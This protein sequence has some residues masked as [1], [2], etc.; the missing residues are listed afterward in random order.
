[1]CTAM[2]KLNARKPFRYSALALACLMLYCARSGLHAGWERRSILPGTDFAT[3]YYIADSGQPGKNVLLFAPHA[4][5][6]SAG[7]ALE[8]FTKRYAPKQGLLIACPWPVVPAKKLQA[9]AYIEDINRQF[10]H[11]ED[12]FTAIDVIAH[13]VQAWLRKYKIDYV[14]N[15]HEGYG[16]FRLSWTANYGQSIFI[17][18]PS[19][20][21]FAES[22]AKRANARIP[23]PD[24]FLTAQL[25]MP[26]T[27]TW[28]CHT[29]GIPSMGI[30]IQRE[31]SKEKRLRYQNIILQEFFSMIGL[32]LEPIKK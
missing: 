15:L 30:E 6:A 28:Y 22:L 31:L 21:P 9:R 11:T 2:Q 1:M 14:L 25:P 13:T 17:D 20:L 5:E 7:L 32:S 24:R 16:K 10:S 29:L 4:D 8:E 18:S 23:E 3:E 26:T 27:F 19:L 12:N